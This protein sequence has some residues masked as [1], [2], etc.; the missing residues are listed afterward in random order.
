MIQS[1]RLWI[2]V[3]SVIGTLLL[4]YFGFVIFFNSHF[5]WHTTVGSVKAGGHSADYVE[6]ENKK[7]A[8]NYILTITDREKTSVGI[9]GSDIDYRYIPKQEEKA[10]LKKQNPFAWPASI[11]HS[12]QLELKASVEY[13]V[14]KFDALFESLPLFSEDYIKAPENAYIEI[15]EEDY[16]VVPEIMGTT[17]KSDVIREQIITALENE[18]AKIKLKDDCYENPEITKDG[19]IMTT[20][21]STIDTY[22]AS[23]I[24]Y[25]IGE[26]D[27]ELSKETILSFIQVDKECNVSIDEDEVAKFVQHLASTYNT[28]GDKREFKTT[29]GDVVTVAG[30]D[31]GW[32]ISKKNEAAQILEDL[33]G[34][35]AVKR[36]PVYEQ[37]AK[38][39]G[40][41]DIGNTYVELDYSNQHFYYYVDGVLTLDADFVSGTMINGNG[42]PDGI[43]KV[44]YCERNAQLVGENY[45]TKVDYFMPFAYNVGFH[46]ASWRDSFGGEIYKTSGSHGC[47][48]LHPDVAKALYDALEVGTPVVAY[49]REP[50]ELT[51][52]SAKI[53]NARSYVEKDDKN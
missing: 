48:N 18:D 37:T 2:I 47:I 26:A 38:Q 51:S 53:S 5:L 24:T 1:K 36:E 9:S 35:E 32:V 52:E 27:E 30:G 6:K 3:G 7:L 8:E 4:I 15:G 13:D 25:D 28:Y 12:Y 29:V 33:K 43:F 42:S 40:A 45:N 34:G 16:A 46:D 41:D 31:Y 19:D 20:A 50:V 21:L 17:P 49:Y 44:I 10:L 14:S 39:I 23:T 11:F 22:L